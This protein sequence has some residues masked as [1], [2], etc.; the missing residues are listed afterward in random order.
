MRYSEAP[1]AEIEARVVVIRRDREWLH[2]RISARLRDRLAAG[3]VDEVRD[4]L[5]NGL[6]PSRLQ[7]VN[8]ALRG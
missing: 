3:M 6:A 5:A 7:M 8:T 1:D 4:L 2:D